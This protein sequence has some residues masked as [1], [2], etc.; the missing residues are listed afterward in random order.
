MQN[1]SIIVLNVLLAVIAAIVAA[2]SDSWLVS[3]LCGCAVATSIA[4]SCTKE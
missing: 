4:I 3:G 1:K 2:L